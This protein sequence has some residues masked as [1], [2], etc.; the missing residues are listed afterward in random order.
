MLR[1]ICSA[2]FE[3]A[4]KLISALL[5]LTSNAIQSL[6]SVISFNQP[7]VPVTQLLF[8]LALPLF[9]LYNMIY[10]LCIFLI[11]GGFNFWPKQLC[12]HNHR[13]S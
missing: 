8:V 3:F 4:V 2:I 7:D 11:K 13:A 10:V 6:T 12:G 1:L 9:P 5:T